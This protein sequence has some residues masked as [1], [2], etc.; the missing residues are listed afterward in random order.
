MSRMPF[1][2]ESQPEARPT[3]LRFWLRL[4]A[5]VVVGGWCAFHWLAHIAG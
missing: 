2:Y 5:V 3:R 1:T 4:A